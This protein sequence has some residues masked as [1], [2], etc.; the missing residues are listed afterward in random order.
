MLGWFNLEKTVVNDKNILRRRKLFMANETY[1]SS[2]HAKWLIP[3]GR[4]RVG[5]TNFGEV[6]KVNFHF[7]ETMKKVHST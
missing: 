2:P 1:F 5:V 4:V 6:D 7:K 3:T